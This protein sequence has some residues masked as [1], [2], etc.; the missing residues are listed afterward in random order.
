[1]NTR[2][3]SELQIITSD[4]NSAYGLLPDFIVADEVC[5]WRSRDL[6]DSLLSAAAKRGHCLLLTITN[7]GFVDSWQHKTREAIRNDP[8][9][10]FSRLDG[11]RASWITQDRLD[12]QR[13]LLPGFQFSRLW[14]NEWTI[15]TDSPLVTEQ[16]LEAAITLPSPT[17]GF[18]EQY[19]PYIGA[20]DIATRRDRT[21][22]VVLGTNIM[23]PRLRLAHVQTWDPARYGGVVPLSQVEADI[24]R[25]ARDAKLLGIAYDPFEAA[26]LAE[27]LAARGIVMFR[28]PWTPPSK[29]KMALYATEAFRHRRVDLYDEQELLRDLRR[30]QVVERAGRVTFELPRDDQGH[31]DAAAAFLMG[32]C[33]ARG[34]R[35]DFLGERDA[36]EIDS[37]A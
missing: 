5:H 28:Y 19:G 3:E 9:W 16:D 37:L 20:L 26:L 6:W 12:E 33:W 30:T 11:P 27:R 25:I 22:F 34:T 23:G 1:M 17:G 36:E 32:L 15:G 31:G 2:T 21:A 4:A 8:T 14:L 24:L 7:A 35:A 18:D 13:R 10:F 29:Q